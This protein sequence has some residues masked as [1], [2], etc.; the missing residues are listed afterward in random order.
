[1]DLEFIKSSTPL[2]RF[3][4][5]LLERLEKMEDNHLILE[6]NIKY[7]KNELK[8]WIIKYIIKD[9][10]NNLKNIV[11]DPNYYGNHLLTSLKRF[12]N[13]KKLIISET[14]VT[15]FH[16]HFKMKTDYLDKSVE[17]S[18]KIFDQMDLE[19]I[20]EF[21]AFDEVPDLLLD[22]ERIHF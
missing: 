13:Y 14:Y 8:I 20:K 10:K 7:S 1:M 18:L 15:D 21:H 22:T 5:M 12:V 2:E 4:I 6:E 11:G 9:Y 19:E 17:L 16:D 3:V